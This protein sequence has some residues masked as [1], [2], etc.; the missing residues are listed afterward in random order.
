MNLSILYH[1]VNEYYFYE[2]YKR[3]CFKLYRDENLR[4]LQLIT[5]FALLL[6][7]VRK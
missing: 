1:F 4:G 3:F 5:L 2:L 6:G 7:Q